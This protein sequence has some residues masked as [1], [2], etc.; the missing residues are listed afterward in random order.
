MA[1]NAS[2]CPFCGAVGDPGDRFCQ[3]CGRDLYA[4]ETAPPPEPGCSFPAPPP[5]PPW[6]AP[7]PARAGLPAWALTVLVIGG[8]AVLAAGGWLG[9]QFLSAQPISPVNAAAR[10]DGTSHPPSDSSPGT[11]P[12]EDII[13][14]PVESALQDG[15]ATPVPDQIQEGGAAEHSASDDPEPSIPSSQDRPKWWKENRAETPAPA[16]A[17][18]AHPSTPPPPPPGATPPAARPSAPPPPDRSPL[19]APT[20]VAP[21]EPVI[22]FSQTHEC[23]KAAE[24][25]IDPEEAQITID[26]KAIGTSDEWDGVLGKAYKFPGPGTY[27]VKLSLLG[28][29][30]EWIKIVVGPEAK[31]KTAMVELEL[32]E[33]P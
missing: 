31:K 15:P 24:F 33:E 17:K 14:A 8:V 19:P 32:A 27:A 2:P 23:R 3:A 22:V 7:R 10:D 25:H 29:R 30:T 11:G 12:A 21:T 26:G 9:Y 5:L 18:P 20:V 1:S 28:Y 4:T 6:P 13:A 16:S